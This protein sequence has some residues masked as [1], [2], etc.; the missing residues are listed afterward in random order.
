MHK[1]GFCEN[2]IRLP[3]T[4]LDVQSQKIIEADLQNQGLL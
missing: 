2:G 3:L 1:M 4:K